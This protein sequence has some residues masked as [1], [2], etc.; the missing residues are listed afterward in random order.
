MYFLERPNSSY[1]SVYSRGP[2]HDVQIDKLGVYMKTNETRNGKPIWIKKHQSIYYHGNLA[3]YSDKTQIC[4]ISLEN[5][6]WLIGEKHQNVGGFK[7]VRSD[8]SD[9]PSEGWLYNDRTKWNDNDTTIT[10]K[11]EGGRDEEGIVFCFLSFSV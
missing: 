4:K 10:V 7:S 3:L 2:A 1:L 9:V 6:H 5:G 8:L 11:G